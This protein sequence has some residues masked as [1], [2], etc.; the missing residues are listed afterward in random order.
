MST[1]GNLE[2][3]PIK[4]LKTNV[5]VPIELLGIV[6]EGTPWGL[7]SVTVDAIYQLVLDYR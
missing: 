3:K 7:P 1:M 2:A 4:H 6:R 5:E